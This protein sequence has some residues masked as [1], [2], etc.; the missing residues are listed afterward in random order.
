MSAL[1][2]AALAGAGQHVGAAGETHE[3][4]AV[5]D[6]DVEFGR[7]RQGFLNGGRQP[8]AQVDVVALAVLQPVDAKLRAFGRDGRVG[9][10]RDGDERCEVDLAGADPAVVMRK[11]RSSGTVVRVSLGTD[12]TPGV[13]ED[14]ELLP[15]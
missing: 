4:L 10:S 3:R 8:R 13:F 9:A 6:I 1:L 2:S 11:D 5:A 14:G 12:G 15:L 7:F